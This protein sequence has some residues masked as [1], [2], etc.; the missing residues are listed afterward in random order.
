VD[1]VGHLYED[2]HDA[3]SLEHK[4]LSLCILRRNR[5]PLLRFT[6]SILFREVTQIFWH[7]LVASLVSLLI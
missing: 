4:V 7:H 2:F 6:V 5:V 3:R 1:L